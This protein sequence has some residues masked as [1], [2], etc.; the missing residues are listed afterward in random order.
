MRD[1]AEAGVER[2]S[3]ADVGLRRTRQ[4]TAVLDALAGCQEFVSARE[5]HSVLSSGGVSVGLTTVYRA[6]H[7]LE[8]AEFVDVVRDEL[9]GRYYRQRPAAGHRHYL[10]CRCCGLSRPVDTDVVERWA[11]R[12]ADDSGFADIEHTLELA[13][14]CADCLSTV[15]AG[16]PPCRQ[17]SHDR[18]ERR[19]CRD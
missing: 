19:T 16:Q 5:L 17:T 6:L 4:R 7:D 8:R 13:G 14:V 11:E 1:K 10:I 3:A 18:T 12:L 2:L 15:T 9:G